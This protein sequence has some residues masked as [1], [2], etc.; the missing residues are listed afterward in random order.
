MDAAVPVDANSRAHRDLQNRADRG[1]TQRPQPSSTR[2]N[3]N[4]EQLETRPVPRPLFKFARSQVNANTPGGSP[5]AAGGDAPWRRAVGGVSEADSGRSANP[6]GVGA[7]FLWDDRPP[8]CNSL[9]LDHVLIL[10]E[11]HLRQVLAEWVRHFNGARPHQG[12]GQQIP[13][14]G[15]RPARAE[16][17]GSIVAFPVLGGLHHDY[18]R[19]A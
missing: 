19:A 3:K 11:E 18:R 10:G 1:F 13:S 4:L 12:I 16:P 9:S 14:Q 5:T 7:P 15:R 8:F 2:E 17:R 6:R